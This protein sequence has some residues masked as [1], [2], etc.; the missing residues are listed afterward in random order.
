MD[1]DFDTFNKQIKLMID[2]L[3]KLPKLNDV[4]L[5]FEGGSLNGYYLFGVALFLKELERRGAIRVNKISATSIGAYIAFHYLNDTLS[6]AY[7]HTLNAKQSFIE[8]LNMSYFKEAVAADVSGINVKTLNDRLF[9][10]YYNVVP[11]RK[12]VIQSNF[13]DTSDLY[14]ALCASAYLPILMDGDTTYKCKKGN[15]RCIDGGLPYLF[16]DDN[17]NTLYVKLSGWN[18]LGNMF[19]HRGEKNGRGRVC[20]G[21][22]SAYNFFLYGEP[23]S[24]MCSWVSNWTT[25]DRVVYSIKHAFCLIVSLIVY[26]VVLGYHWFIT[27]NQS[28]LN[29]LLDNDDD[30]TIIFVKIRDT[31]NDLLIAVIT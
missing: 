3:E 27:N 22:V 20:E 23:G 13:T 24:D 7:K 2:N 16:D 25:F 6:D 12:R 17:E 4:N 26:G 9:I 15:R 10:T 14:D 1:G 5:I 28:V 21:I 30:L 8:R 31:F 19:N 11:E 29:D 18:K